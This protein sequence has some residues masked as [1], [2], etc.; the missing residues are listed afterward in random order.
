M[1]KTNKAALARELERQV[2]QAAEPIPEPSTTI[3]DMSLVQKKKGNDHIFSQL[4]DSAKTH[5]LHEGVRSHRIDVIFETHLED[6]TKNAGGALQE[7]SHETLRQVSGSS[8]GES[9]SAARPT[10]SAS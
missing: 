5:V 1:R 2:L 9:L 6:S 10:G 3:I 7:Y 4:T 8:N